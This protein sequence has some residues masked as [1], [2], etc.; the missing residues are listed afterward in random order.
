MAKTIGPSFPDEL[1]GAG[2]ANKVGSFVIGGTNA[3][4]YAPNL[5]GADQTTLNNIVAAHNSATPA[6]GPTAAQLDAM[7]DRAIQYERALKAVVL[8]IND[9]TL[10]VGGNK[11]GVQ[12]K[13]II[14]AKM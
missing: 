12:L 11:T 2:L 14:K 10:V 9:G 5:S 8:A 3:D 6:A 13:A 7:Y 4:I 1:H